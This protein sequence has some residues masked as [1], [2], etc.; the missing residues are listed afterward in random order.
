MELPKKKKKHPLAKELNVDAD[1]DL[2][3]HEKFTDDKG[4]KMMEKKEEE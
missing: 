3:V 2:P 1:S 4:I